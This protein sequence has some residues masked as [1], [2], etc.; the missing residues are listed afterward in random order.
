MKRIFFIISLPLILLAGCQV[1]A[2]RAA[3][4][5]ATSSEYITGNPW[6]LFFLAGLLVFLAG[7]VCKIIG[8]ATR[9]AAVIIGLGYLMA[10]VGSFSMKHSWL[11]ALAGAAVIVG[12]GVLAYFYMRDRFA[13]ETIVKAVDATPGGADV[14]KTI[15]AQGSSVTKV[16]DKVIDPLKD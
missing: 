2:A 5:T 7:V 13:L 11:P 15:A 9:D 12:A 3:A 8:F 6:F 4:Q 1:T 16:I 14:K 10:C